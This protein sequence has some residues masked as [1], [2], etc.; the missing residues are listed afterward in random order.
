MIIT[1]NDN[2]NIIIATR[3]YFQQI[4][5]QISLPRD[6]MLYVMFLLCLSDVIFLVCMWSDSFWPGWVAQYSRLWLSSWI[7]HVSI[8][9]QE[10][11]AT[12]GFLSPW[13]LANLFYFWMLTSRDV[14]GECI[15]DVSLYVQEMCPMLN[16]LFLMIATYLTLNT[17]YFSLD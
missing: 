8:F 9:V 2:N 15:P 11:C 10:T 16:Y 3:V 4:H 17:P 5:V 6:N 1:I 12:L 14:V 7:P 13:L